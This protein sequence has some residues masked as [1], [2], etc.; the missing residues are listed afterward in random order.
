LAYGILG[1]WFVIASAMLARGGTAYLRLAR[2]LRRCPA[3]TDPAI[4]SQVSRACRAVG[5]RRRPVLKEVEGLSVPAVFGLCRHTICLPPGTTSQLRADELRWVLMH[6]IA[7]IKRHDSLLLSVAMFMRACHWFNPLA[8]LIVSRLRNHMEQAADDVAMRSEPERSLVDYGR[9]LLRYASQQNAMSQPAT[10]GLLFVSSAKSLRQRIEMLD[11]NHRRNHWLARHVAIAG[12][13]SI[14][15]SGLTDA[16]T[17]E[18]QQQVA[19]DYRQPNIV[20]ANSPDPVP[21]FEQPK[22]AEP[23]VE[24]SYDVSRVLAKLQESYSDKESEIYLTSFFGQLAPGS[25]RLSDG[26]LTVIQT[27]RAHRFTKRMLQAWEQSGPEWQISIECHVIHADL[28][29]ARGIDWTRDGVVP[30]SDDRGSDPGTLRAESIEFPDEFLF[31][32]SKD[33]AFESRDESVRSRPSIAAK[34]SS[35]QAQLLLHRCRR[36]VTASALQAP[37]VTLFN[38]QHAVIQD[39]V[40][41]PFVTGIRPGVGA[42]KLEPIIETIAE[43]WRMELLAEVT[44]AE[45]IDLRCVLTQSEIEKVEMANLPFLAEETPSTN[46]TVQV[47]SVTRSTVRSSVRLARNQCLL[48]ASPTTFKSAA[49]GR[50]SRARF[51]LITP[52]LIPPQ[53]TVVEGS[54]EPKA[55]D[56]NQVGTNVLIPHDH[57]PTA[58]Q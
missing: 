35:F 44:E 58:K 3:L 27:A 50:A 32:G 54:R 39:E 4:E 1:T 8:W 45:Q 23:V 51:Y 47:P 14:A 40:Q 28:Q 49:N 52:R 30:A 55:E 31:D 53:Y 21:D 43:G 15:I 17:V 24:V 46:L 18:P 48:I 36:D 20:A 37:K 10:M 34:I 56:L 19:T 25:A 2:R 22:P 26:Q 9:L 7:H 33:F 41:R 13:A 42:V 11:Q 57:P 5:A 6:E 12:I 38:G 16:R 29:V